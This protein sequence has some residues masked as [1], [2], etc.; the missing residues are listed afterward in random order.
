MNFQTNILLK[1]VVLDHYPSTM[2]LHLAL[3]RPDVDSIPT[4]VGHVTLEWV[5]LDDHYWFLSFTPVRLVDG[6][7]PAKT[8]YVFIELVPF[9][10]DFV[11][12]S[13]YV[14]EAYPLKGIEILLKV[15][16]LRE[17]SLEKPL[18]LMGVLVTNAE[19]EL[20]ELHIGDAI[21][22]LLK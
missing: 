10:Y 21:I 11:F 5:V 4:E 12:V 16:I 1:G 3:C 22:E 17:N 15:F 6:H 13:W 18:I 19:L 2:G 9:K 8:A 20:R 14:D 7:S